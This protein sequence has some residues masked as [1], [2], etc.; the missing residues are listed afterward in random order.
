MAYTGSKAQAGRGSSLSIGSSVTPTGTTTTSST[1]ITGV[2]ST[3]GIAVG[4]SISGTG[5]PANTTITAISGNTLTISNAATATGSVT[6]TISPVILGEIKSVPFKAGKWETADVTNFQSGSDR[7]FIT[8]VRDNGTV[9]LAGNRVSGDAGQQAIEA[10]YSSGGI[11]AFTL[12]L[13]LA[14]GQSTS[15]DKYTFNALVVSRDFT[16]DVTKEIDW[17]VSLKISGAVTFAAGS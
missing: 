9:D 8:T 2:T 3:S 5:I 14:S 17:Q 13:P 16:V 1:S 12:Q 10:A 4:A 11:S 15:G 6:L 7:E